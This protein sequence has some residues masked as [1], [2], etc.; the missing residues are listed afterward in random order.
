VKKTYRACYWVAN[1]RQSDV[2]LT[3]EA[4]ANLPDEDLLA[5]ARRNAHEIG[6][7]LSTGELKV[8]EWRPFNL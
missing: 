4:Q 6:L 5:I 3:C 8:G 7:D 2:V 1:D